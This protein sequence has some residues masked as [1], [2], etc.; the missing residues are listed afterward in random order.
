MRM[1]YFLM[2]WMPYKQLIEKHSCHFRSSTHLM[3]ELETDP[4]LQIISQNDHNRVCKQ[5][6][7]HTYFE[8]DGNGNVDVD[9]DHDHDDDADCRE[10]IHKQSIMEQRR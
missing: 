4:E 9:H 10:R 5:T 7:K 8:V 1:S 2:D 6:N 3:T